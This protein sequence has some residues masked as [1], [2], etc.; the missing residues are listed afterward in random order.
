MEERQRE[1]EGRLELL[2]QGVHH[3]S[4]LIRH[5]LEDLHISKGSAAH[6]ESHQHTIVIAGIAHNEHTYVILPKRE[7][8]HQ[9]RATE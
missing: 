2:L 9:I 6:T 3:R 4:T 7:Y 1:P 8:R 5:L